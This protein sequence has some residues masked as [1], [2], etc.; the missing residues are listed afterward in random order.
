MQKKTMHPK[1]WIT[2]AAA[3]CLTISSTTGCGKTEEVSAEV[4]PVAVETVIPVKGDIVLEREFIATITTENTVSVIPKATGEVM[5][6][7]VKTGDIVEKGQTLFTIDAEALDS[8]IRDLNQ[9]LERTQR[10]YQNALEDYQDMLDEQ[11]KLTIKANISGYVKSIDVE[12]G[13]EVAMGTQLAHLLDNY[14]MEI[15]VPFL[16]DEIQE[17]WIGQEAYLEMVNS[18]EGLYGT[19]TEISGTSEIY[20]A[21]KIIRYVTIRV[22]NPGGISDGMQAI[23]M[24]GGIEG[25]DVA[26]FHIND[27]EIVMPDYPGTIETILVQEGDWAEK[28]QPL[29]TMSSETLENSIDSLKTALDNTRD[30]ITDIQDNKSDT[31]DNLD[32]YTVTAPVSGMI[33]I[34]NVTEHNMVSSGMSAVVISD[35]NQMTASFDVSEDIRNTLSIGQKVGLERNQVSYS[36]T[37]TEI[38]TTVNQKGLFTIKASVDTKGKEIL[39]GTMMSLTTSTYRSNNTLLLPFDTVYYSNEEAYI[40]VEEN[41]HAVKKVISTGLYNEEYI[42]VTEGLTKEEKVISTWSPRLGNGVEVQVVKSTE[43]EIK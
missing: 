40:Y 21:N 35:K 20:G 1:K 29:I 7:F 22:T 38:G 30:A 11:E 4:K 43:E 19:V 25:T 6:V 17:N 5:E 2:L 27:S 14:N 33:D 39:S 34:V 13:D 8:T 37:I 28:D 3:L 24:I 42:E 26:S 16:T 18:G 31:Q 36:G 15:D 12:I 23:A 9:S 10:T 41:N 32:N